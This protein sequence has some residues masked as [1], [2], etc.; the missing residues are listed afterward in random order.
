MAQAAGA[1]LPFDQIIDICGTAGLDLS[2]L[3]QGRIEISDQMACPWR[4]GARSAWYEP[5][6]TPQSSPR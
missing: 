1:R 5:R 6:T 4:P 3:L 2:A